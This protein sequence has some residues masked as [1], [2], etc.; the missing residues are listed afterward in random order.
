MAEFPLIPTRTKIALARHLYRV[1]MVPR[2]LLGLGTQ[3]RV[4]RRGILWDLDLREGIDLAIYLFGE[5]ERSTVRAYSRM[6]RPG[7]TVF[8]IG[9]NIGAHTLPL[10]RAVGPSGRVIAFEATAGAVAKLESNLALNPVLAPRVVTRQSFLCELGGR[11]PAHLVYASWPV[12][13]RAIAPE[14]HPLH[15]GVPASTDGAACETLDH[16]W[17]ALGCPPVTFVKLDVDGNEPAVLR[18]GAR[19]L[20]Q[21]R[22]IILTELA[23]Y[24]HVERGEPAD[25]LQRLLTDAGYRLYD[26]A[27]HV[28]ASAGVSRLRAGAST[29]VVAKPT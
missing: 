29:N 25:V 3:V 28:F 13:G 17:E 15:R 6:V 5:F 9:A 4:R 19:L 20:Q 23:P 11:R 26:M 14:T 8:D 16:A 12:D 24:G 10:A 18:G 27:G 2:R 1:V 22:P 7:A 21:Q